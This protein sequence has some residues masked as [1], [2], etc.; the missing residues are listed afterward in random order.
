MSMQLFQEEEVK[1]LVQN[2][3]QRNLMRKNF[4]GFKL[5]YQAHYLT[6]PPADFHP[7]LSR[8]FQDEKEQFL[9]IIGF[10]GSAK[11]SDG[12]VALPLF[13][14]LQQPE[15]YPF[16]IIVNET[17]PAVAE[18]IA[19]IRKELEQNTLLREDYGDMSQGVSKLREWTKTSLVLG[20]GVKILG[21]SRGQR[22]RGRRH[23]QHRPSVVIVDDPEEMVK[24]EKKE[25]RDKTEK[26]IRGEVIPAMEETGGRLIVLG[27][28]LHTDAIMARLKNDPI[29]THREYALFNGPEK[30]ENCTW[31]GKYPTQE[32]LDKQKAKVR[33]TAWS[34]EY[35]LKVVPPEG[36]IIKPEWIQYYDEVP[37]P[38]YET[39]PRTKQQV[40]VSN[41]ILS[42][43][44][45]NDLAISKKE[46]ADY[47]TFVPGVMATH[48]NRARIFILPQIV[49]ERL[50]FQ[51][52]IAR[53]RTLYNAIRTRYAAPM[54]FTEDVAYQRAAVEMLAA[55]GI[56]VQGIKVGTDKRTRL[57]MIAPFI[58]NGTVLFPKK[59]AE[60]LIGQ[61]LG[62]GIE[63]HDDISDGLVNLV[64]GV[65]SV[66][67]MQPLDVI[68]LG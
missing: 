6:L 59:G 49:N 31:K 25:Y 48:E 45:G 66:S 60:E 52:T 5:L 18:S 26:W 7:E 65:N 36:Q 68:A 3:E 24:V 57:L 55:A 4:L 23:R 54:F 47:T 67:G 42:A 30:W 10:R 51:E 40:L 64:L 8:L 43:G 20:N 29:F 21:L 46:T 22:I 62:F 17:I 44:V 15:R 50:N 27:N 28:I 37:G 16:I 58:E 13:M 35:C 41:P 38:V 56:P 11:S 53:G 2:R 61:L 9:S 12:S 32:A 1:Q 63:E 19:N 33:Y 14:A 34:R 39:D